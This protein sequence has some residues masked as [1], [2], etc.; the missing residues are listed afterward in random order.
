MARGLAITQI[1]RALRLERKTVRRYATADQLIG[2]PRLSRPGLLGPHHA[3]LRQRWDDGCH[4]TSQ[5]HTEL[6]VRG[7]RDSLRRL[8]AQLRHDSTIPTPP[9]GLTSDDH[10]KLAQI[11]ARCEELALTRDLVCEFAD[12]LCNQRR[13]RLEAW[14]TQAPVSPVPELRGLANGL[15]KNWAAVTAGLTTPYSSGAVEGHVTFKML[16]RQMYSRA[17]PD[18]LRKRILLAG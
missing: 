1:S 7:Y 5:L 15:R 12:M 13:E 9:S 16:M 2:G 14:A 4:S 18:L 8:T 3:Y 6:R 11:T 17:R 10:A